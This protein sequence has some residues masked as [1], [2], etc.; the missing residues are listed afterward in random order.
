[1][2]ENDFYKTGRIDDYLFLKSCLKERRENGTADKDKG[3]NNK[4]D[5]LR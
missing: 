2:K 5:K 3:N 1:M 4:T